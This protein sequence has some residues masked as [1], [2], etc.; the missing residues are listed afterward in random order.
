MMYSPYSSYYATP[1]M[2]PYSYYYGYPTTYPYYAQGNVWVPQ[3]SPVNRTAQV[4]RV[5]PSAQVAP[6]KNQLKKLFHNRQAVTYA[7]HLR[8]FAAK[9]KNGDG[10]IDPTLGESG[11][12]LR[13]IPLLKELKAL[14]VNNIHLLP[15]NPVGKIDRLG[16]FGSPG[17]A[18]SPGAYDR[19]N[20][21]Y[22][23]PNNQLSVIQEAR[24]FVDEAHKLGIHVMVDIPSCASID[25][26]RARPDL[27]ARD[28]HGNLLTPT[29]WVDIRMFVKDSPA[30]REYFG[31]YFDLM[32]NKV[33]VD[34]FRADIARARTMSFWSNFIQ[35]YPDKAW[36]AET[37]TEEDASPMKNL[38]RD[39]PED[40]L[41]AGFDAI[42]GQFHIFHD[43]DANQY[44]RYLQQ[45]QEMLKR[46]GPKKSIIGSFLTH[47]DPSTMEQGGALYNKLIAGLMAVQPDTNPYI[48]DGFT[49]GYARHYDI[50]N[51]KPR[52]T[53]NHPEIGTFL[54]KMLAVRQ[55]RQYGSILTQGQFVPLTINQDK[56][57][58]RI[59]AFLRQQG[60][61]TL[62]VVAN[63]DVNAAHKATI[64]IP[65]LD[66][67][68]KLVN[69]APNYGEKS[70]FIVNNGQI[71][72]TLERGRF[73]LFEISLPPS[74]NN[75][76]TNK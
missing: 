61:R 39:V 13:A 41:K 45:N 25:L 29:N 60:N 24:M 55:S 67:R 46:V 42:Y 40:L 19:L 51:W 8:T 16:D 57:D 23:E 21:E 72:T 20:E 65:G 18:Y 48:L 10:T 52:P 12:L 34:G 7:L 58:P 54:Q 11:N 36:L 75:T 28:I 30:L 4:S 76:V 33:G 50:F 44:I 74:A 73:Y 49:T 63:K 35:K 53:G 17:S 69:I 26:S 43:M 70:T 56:R 31:R 15:I 22:D 14:G 6:W 32:I 2:S 66:I 47:D 64:E 1:G 38:P 3:Q 27:M 71:A 37:Y 62:L 5:T 59:I 9:D 68:Q